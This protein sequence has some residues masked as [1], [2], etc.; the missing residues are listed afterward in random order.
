[1]LGV[2]DVVAKSLG[3]TNPYNMVRATFDALKGQENPRAVA[4]RR[5]KKVSEIVARRRDGS[6]GEAERRGRGGV[7]RGAVR[8]QL[9]KDRQ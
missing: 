7:K 5:G 6:A 3:C 4:A 2:H 9:R 1:M 8:W